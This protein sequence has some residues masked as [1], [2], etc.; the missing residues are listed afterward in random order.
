ME[1]S[2]PTDFKDWANRI[3]SFRS[4]F[5]GLL[6][7]MVMVSEL[8]FDWL[9]QAVGAFLVTTNAGRPESG[10]IWEI[11]NQTRTAQKTLEQL[12]SDKQSSQREARSATSFKRIAATIEPDQWIMI[13]PDRFRFLYLKLSP[14]TAEEILPSLE[15]LA[16]ITDKQWD[17]TYFEKDGKGLKIYLLDK[18]NRVLKQLGISPDLLYYMEQSE[19]ELAESLDYFQKFDNRIYPADRF[20]QGLQS[21]DETVQKGVLPRPENLLRVPGQIIRVGISDEALSG[22][23]ELGFEIESGTQRTVLL[24]Q[25]H[26]WAVWRLRSILERQEIEGSTPERSLSP[27]SEPGNTVKFPG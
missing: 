23:I 1:W 14:E 21:L 18:N 17:R 16:L 2:D 27:E 3:F 20:F 8:R 6:L 25:G 22:F 15:L 13:S 19:M 4:L 11:G 26:E 12:V 9:E 5:I 10:I 24:L 7:L